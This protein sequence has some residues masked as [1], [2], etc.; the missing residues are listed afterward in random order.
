MARGD[1]RCV[2]RRAAVSCVFD[3]GRCD[4]AMLDLGPIVLGCDGQVNLAAKGKAPIRWRS[5]AMCGEYAERT[6]GEG[7]R[8]QGWANEAWE[9]TQRGHVDKQCT[10]DEERTQSECGFTL[11]NRRIG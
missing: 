7:G 1:A 8:E 5:G 3:V 10:Q 11:R 4:G 9:G 6:A 2:L